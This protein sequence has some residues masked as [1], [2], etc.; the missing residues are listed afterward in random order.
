M[1]LMLLAMHT[2]VFMFENP[3]R[4]KASAQAPPPSSLAGVSQQEDCRARTFLHCCHS[5]IIKL[6]KVEA[7]IKIQEMLPDR[8]VRNAISLP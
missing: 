4:C 2:C 6:L 8:V 7:V 5:R 3:L 1:I